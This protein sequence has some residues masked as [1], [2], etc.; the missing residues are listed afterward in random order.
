MKL[1]NKQKI[2]KIKE[3]LNNYETIWTYNQLK[4]LN[5]IKEIIEDKTF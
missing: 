3:I 5:K 1:S 2:E 4:A